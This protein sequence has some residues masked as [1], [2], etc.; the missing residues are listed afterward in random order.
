[1]FS[2]S[3]ITLRK[4]FKLICLLLFI[5][6]F[7]QCEKEP[8]IEKKPIIVPLTHY[9]SVAI[10]KLPR[11]YNFLKTMKEAG[12]TFIDFRTYMRTDTS[13]L[14]RKLIVIRHDIHYRDIS[15]A[16]FAFQIEQIVI[17]LRHSTYYVMLNDPLELKVINPA[18]K[19]QYM[20]LVHLLD[21]NEIDIQPHISP[22]D[23]YIS[24]N[25]P[26]WEKFSVDSLTRMFN[27]NYRWDI[28]KTGRNLIVTGK[29]V[30]NINDINKSLIPL[31]LKYNEEWTYETDH[32]VQGY[33]SHGSG[34]AMNHILNNAYILDQLA[35]L[36]IGLYKYDTYNSKIFNVLTYLS[37]NYLPSWMRDPGTIPPGRYQFLMHPYQWTTNRVKSTEPF[38]EEIYDE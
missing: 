19:S 14:P 4:F 8:P 24:N 27:H 1:M 32:D 18:M 29:D 10:A 23:M 28:N 34:T 11:Y 9:D 30:F 2:R 26:Y 17:G 25:H 37:D 16:Y 38:E 3:L 13:R 35:L 12:Y 7:F 6:L 21:S 5:S 15:Y 36:R 20:K 33:A 22:I 31:L